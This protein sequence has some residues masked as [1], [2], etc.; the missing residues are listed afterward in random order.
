MA[1]H[2]ERW[3]SAPDV[4]EQSVDTLIIGH[5]TRDLLPDGGWR[6]GG[7]AFYAAVTAHRLGRR[8]G[9]VTSAPTDVCASVCATL[10]DVALVALPAET[11]TTFVNVY[12]AAGRV[13]YLRASAQP[14]TLDDIPPT[15]RHCEV[16]LLAPVARELSPDLA[17]GL[18]ARV[19]GAAPQGWLRQWSADGRVRPRPLASDEEEA[20][21]R[22][23]ALILSRED[24]TGPAAD[25]EALATAEQTLA[26]W[27]RLVP[28]LAV[29]RGSEGAELWR[30]G[31]VERIAGY[32]AREVDPTGAGDVFAATF[33]CALASMSDP[34][35]AI[36]LANRVAA[37]S[38]EGVG[39]SA[40]PTRE[41]AAA[42]YAGR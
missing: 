41:Q 14:I 2:G 23:S 1:E 7:A 36:D 9:V 17:R 11:A 37:I 6:P 35:V 39:A 18:T 15:W 24:L 40:I 42:R 4:T 34:V 30:A 22:F 20:L 13:Q 5:V 8:V 33:L 3:L 26:T 10:G 25:A 16:A 19:I 38:V 29:T 32:P 28:L 12:T 31:A 27:A 21:R